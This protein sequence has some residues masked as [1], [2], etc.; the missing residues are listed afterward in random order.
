MELIILEFKILD[1]I[2]VELNITD[3][4]NEELIVVKF[5]VF[6]RLVLDF[7]IVEL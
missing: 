5:I 2:I 6:V 1:L 4:F 7:E 3:I